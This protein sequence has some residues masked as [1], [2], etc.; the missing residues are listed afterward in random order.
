MLRKYPVRK[1][2]R[3]LR[4]MQ[5]MSSVYASP[6]SLPPSVDLRSKMSPV[7][8]QGQLGSCTANAIVSGLREYLMLQHGGTY[9]PLSRLYL[10]WHERQLEGNVN[11]DAGAYIRDGMKVLQKNGVCPEADY[12]Y[13]P[14][15]FREA[16]TP[17]AESGAHFFF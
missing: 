8:D 14:S 9:T 1:D 4:D 3:D 11:E 13:V 16:P 5:F 2:P 12:P 6:A 17:Q 10:Y 7:V 15:H